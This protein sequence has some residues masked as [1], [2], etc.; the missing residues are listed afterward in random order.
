MILIVS[1]GGFHLDGLAD[2]FDALSVKSSGDHAADRERRLRV[3]KDSTTGAIGVI[4]IVMTMLLK[5]LFLNNLFSSS[6]FG[7]AALFI[8]VFDA[9]IFKVGDGTQHVSRDIS[10]TGR[11]GKDVHRKHHLVL[12]LSLH[13]YNVGIFLLY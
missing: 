6:L 13:P 2:T 9:G 11:A 10:P 7:T 8:A 5:F 4:A 1:N 12:S 3:M